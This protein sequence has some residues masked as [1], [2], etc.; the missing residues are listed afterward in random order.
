MIEKSIT[1]KID[2]PIR[3]E[4]SLKEDLAKKEVS[5]DLNKI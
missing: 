4:S 5:R 3:L 1:S 2:K